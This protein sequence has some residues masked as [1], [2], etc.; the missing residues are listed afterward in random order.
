M[1]CLICKDENVDL[2][3]IYTCT[4]ALLC[5]DCLELSQNNIHI[6]PLCRN[7]LKFNRKWDYC[8]F[9]LLI[10]LEL[11]ISFT[12]IIVPLIY[13]ILLLLNNND[14]SSIVLFL[15]SVYFV[16]C[17]DPVNINF[18]QKYTPITYIYLQLL[19]ILCIIVMYFVL[20]VMSSE[21][22]INLYIIGILIPFFIT[23]NLIFSCSI[24]YKLIKDIIDYNNKKTLVKK[25]KCLGITQPIDVIL[26]NEL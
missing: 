19:K 21:Y 6:C 1:S 12:I 5:N 22:K 11:L 7:K 13:P 10:L 3:R 8:N 4:D 2:Y 25:I 24:N 16:L 26:V 23:P 20:L 15:S 18:I 14:T 17:V 9:I